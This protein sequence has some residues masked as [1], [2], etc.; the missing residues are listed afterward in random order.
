M[1]ANDAEFL[2]GLAGVAA[3][4]N[5]AFIVG[6]FF[7]MDSEQHRQLTASLAADLYLRAG[8]RW[9]FVMLAMPMFVSLA[10]VA[11]EPLIGAI[12]FAISG[13]ILIFSTID[14]A[15]RILA[16]RGKGTSR[17]LHVNQWFNAVSVLVIVVLPWVLGG[18]LPTV[19]AY[20]PSLMLSLV[21]GFTST[22]ALVMAQFDA[23]MGMVQETDRTQDD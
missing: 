14:T 19:E 6:V 7:Y 12:V 22:A 23:T 21:A 2:I 4:L 15:L 18:W 20:V 8:V 11:M 5:G 17:T 13:V 1:I 9:I 10:L 3:T 16:G